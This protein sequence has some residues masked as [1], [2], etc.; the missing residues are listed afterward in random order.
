MT[1]LSKVWNQIEWLHKSS[2]S[3]IP[4]RDKQQGEYPAKTP[5]RG[6]KQYQSEQITLPDLWSQMEQHKTEAVAIICGKV[7][8]NLHLID[9]DVKYK[10]GIDAV[11]FSDFRSI[12]PDLFSRLRIH[13][14]PSGGY[15]MLYRIDLPQGQG[16]PQNV[17]LAGR[18]ATDAELILR[19]KTKAYN[20]LETRGEGG[21][22]VAPPSLGYTVYQDVA[23]PVVSWEDHCSII[24]LCRSYSELIEPKP[25]TPSKQDREYYTENPFEHFNASAE[26]ETILT[27]YGWKFLKQSNLFLWF[28]RPDKTGGISASFNRQ[29]RVYFIFTSSTEFDESRGYNPATI[30]SILAHNGDKKKTY[31]HLVQKGYGKINPEVEKRIAHNNAVSGRPLPPNASKEAKANHAAALVTI[32]TTYPYGIFW[33]KDEDQKT[34]ISREKLYT[35]A[36]GLGWRLH[37]SEPVRIQG[38]IVA[39]KTE[40]DLYDSLKSYIK[41]EDADEYIEIANAF[42]AFI[43][44]NGS[45]T[46]TRLPFLDTSTI[47]RDTNNSAYKFY[48]NGY[49]FI[50]ATGYQ[51]NTYDT[52]SGMIWEH[53]IIARQYNPGPPDGRYME[54]LKLA[55]P[56][57]EQGDHIRKVIGYLSHQYKDETI[58]YIIVLTEQCQ[59]AK[60]GGGSGKNIFTSLFSNTT[61]VKTIPGSQISYDAK[62]MQSWNRERL[63]VI[64]DVP[65]KFDFMFLKEPSTGSAILKK[66]FKD[67]LVIPVEDMCKF[68][69]N[70]NYSYEVSDGGLRRRL[71]PIEFTDHFTRCGG[72]DVHFGCHF[73]KGWELQD[74]TGYDNFIAKCVQDWLAGGLKL[75][76]PQLTESGWHKQFEQTW[77][78]VVTGIIE[79]MLEGWQKKEWISNQAFKDD[80]DIYFKENNTP[81]SY[82]PAMSRIL[83]GLK[84]WCNHKGYEFSANT[85]HRNELG[86]P[87]KHKWFGKVGDTPF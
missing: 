46:I 52:L 40:R 60:Q 78:Q 65:K 7:S 49:L 1:D 77:G 72:V 71:I 27:D 3:L 70:T 18:P 21:Y 56:Y 31:R 32:Q 73:P 66:L 43:Q 14:T 22:A 51:F 10:P 30:L 33:A 82:R 19:P 85:L 38:Y 76:P 67:E 61:T 15:H 53:D 84:E 6:W 55:T 4:V 12:Y 54:Y 75:Y 29:K 2:I 74:W 79:E 58:G 41:E 16:M 37:G 44:R 64:S 13:K 63:F 83:D 24:N 39:R 5:Y 35:V 17:K 28:T 20:F 45:F 80:I 8:G 87:V 11:L 25:Y 59:D 57:E 36:E 23:I 50:T 26:A 62:F 9:I 42:E 48:N 47:A 86:V 69:V 34:V 68:V 81:V